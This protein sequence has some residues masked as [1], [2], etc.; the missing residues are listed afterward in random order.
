MKTARLAALLVSGG[1]CTA[2]SALAQSPAA[3]GAAPAA[4][5]AEEAPLFRLY[6]IFTPR[7]VVSDRAVDTFNQPNASAITM[8]GD[9]IFSVAP[10]RPRYTLQ[11][12]QSRI[13]VWIHEKGPVRGQLEVDFID[14]TRSTPTVASL[15]RLRIARVDYT[16]SPGHTLALGQDWDLHAPL[17]AHG[18]NLVGTLF[19][20]GNT[21]FMRQQFKYLYSGSSFDLGAAVGFPAPNVTARE[22]ALEI[23][24]LPTLAVRGAYKFG[25]S[26]V[27]VS[28]IYTRL[29]FNFGAQDE[30]IGDAFAAVLFSELAPT[31]STQVRLELN[32]GQNTANLGLLS[33]AQGNASQDL[34][35]AGGFLSV[36]Q[37]LAEQHAVYGL[38][39]YQKVLEGYAV[40]PAYSYPGTTSPDNPPPFTSAV[41]AGTGPGALHNGAARL[42]YEFKPLG[43]LAFMVEGFYYRT[44]FALQA[45]D[46]ARANPVSSALGIEAGA[47]FTF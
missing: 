16:F 43:S 17:N 2:S 1:L 10:D 19:Q 31:A 28:A 5:V 21:G 15:P 26:R 20:A 39:G 34:S 13:G 47:L 32:Y 22:A 36:R 42:G 4:A 27:G 44:R 11:V 24:A 3:G 25:K 41:L 29:P 37:Q 23:G 38:V 7:V 45:V 9:P 40:V 30:R 35:E 6:G 18:I 46:V 8:A 33:L 12:A 14:F